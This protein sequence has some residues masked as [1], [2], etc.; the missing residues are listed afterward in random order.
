MVAWTCNPNIQEVEPK[1]FKV[2]G[3]LE[4]CS[5]TLPKKGKKTVSFPLQTQLIFTMGMCILMNI[6]AHCLYFVVNLDGKRLKGK[7]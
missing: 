2:Q 5:Q 3:Q 7:K 1:G 6:K 4:L